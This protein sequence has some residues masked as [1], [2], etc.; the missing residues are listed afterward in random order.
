M[1][2]FDRR[3]LRSRSTNHCAP[4]CRFVAYGIDTHAGLIYKRCRKCYRIRIVKQ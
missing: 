2:V 1:S 4:R 3:L